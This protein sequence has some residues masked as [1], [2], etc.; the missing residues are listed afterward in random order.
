MKQRRAAPPA[1]RSASPPSASGGDDGADA[2]VP[3][4]RVVV[5]ERGV[6]VGVGARFVGVLVPHPRALVEVRVLHREVGLAEAPVGDRMELHQVQAPAGAEE[7]VRRPPPTRRCPG[8]SRARRSRCRRGR[9][10]D[11]GEWSARRTRWPP[12]TRP[13]APPRPRARGPRGSPARSD[14][15]RRPGRRGAPSRGCPCRSGTGGGRGRARRRRRPPRSR[16][17]EVACY[18]PKSGRTP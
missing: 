9:T 14:P 18:L 12:R 8:A 5:L 13:R 6:G 16:S 3:L 15:R 17:H 1:I 11:H 7:V 4:D 2:V 10:F